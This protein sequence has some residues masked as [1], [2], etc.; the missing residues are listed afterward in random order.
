MMERSYDIFENMNEIS[1]ISYKGKQVRVS[2]KGKNIETDIEK[3]LFLV[4][5][6]E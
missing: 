6:L 3:A 5:K 1:R 2:Y 4:G